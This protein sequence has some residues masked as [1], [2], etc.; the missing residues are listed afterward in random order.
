MEAD[1]IGSR[2]RIRSYA[3]ARLERLFAAA[4]AAFLGVFLVW[5]VGFSPIGV[6]HNAAHDTRHSTGFPC[7]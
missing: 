6:V 3:T 7:H 1:V 5:G 2:Q 4:L